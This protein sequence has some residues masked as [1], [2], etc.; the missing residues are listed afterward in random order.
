MSDLPSVALANPFDKELWGEVPFGFWALV[1]FTFG[2]VVGSFLNVCIHRMPLGQSVVSPPS[3]CP[4]CRYSIP[5]FLNIPLVTWVWLR[6]RCANC[7]AP[8]SARYFG[9]ELLTGLAFLACWWRYGALSPGM[10]LGYSLLMAGF[11]VATFIDLEHFIIPDEITLGGTIA[12][13]L[14]SIAIP[15]LHGSPGRP[16]A[17]LAASVAGALTGFLITYGVLRLGKLLFGRQVIRLADRTQVHFKE[18]G[19]E[20]EGETTPYDEIFYRP[21]DRILLEAKKVVGMGKT[22]ENVKVTLSP[23]QLTIGTETFDP[24]KV[25][26]LACWTDR[27]VLPREAMGFGDVKFMAAIGAFLGWRG[28][29]FSLLSSAMIG[30]VVGLLLIALQKREWSARLPYG[31]YIAAA[32]T[33]WVLFGGRELMQRLYGW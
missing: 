10:A 23:R 3:H 18:T 15:A 28:A 6:G 7:K 11:V 27:I 25:P 24:E 1:F 29:I 8:I 12:G 32:A 16:L 2:S 13:I 4:H 31:P 20:I 22:W 21:S 14:G 19:V 30:A 5:W 33:W 26:D 17:G 9:V